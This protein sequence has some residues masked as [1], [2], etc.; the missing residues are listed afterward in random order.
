MRSTF[1]KGER[2]LRALLTDSCKPGLEGDM[3]VIR[4]ACDKLWDIARSEGLSEGSWPV[5]GCA[6]Y[7]GAHMKSYGGRGKREPHF[8]HH[9]VE[10]VPD[11]HQSNHTIL[12]GG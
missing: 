1:P 7:T 2:L 5:A 3:D 4:L 8:L 12:S 10:C 11:L 6:E 9:F